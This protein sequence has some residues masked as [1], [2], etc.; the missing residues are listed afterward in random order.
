[1]PKRYIIFAILAT[2]I[3]NMFIVW[4]MS[5]GLGVE[6][7][8]WCWMSNIC[9]CCSFKWGQVLQSVPSKYYKGALTQKRSFLVICTTFS[10]DFHVWWKT[11]NKNSTLNWLRRSVQM[12]WIRHKE[13][14]RLVKWHQVIWKFLLMISRTN[15]IKKN[16]R[17]S[18]NVTNYDFFLNS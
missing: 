9:Y 5:F 15:L 3:C 6:C 10:S 14:L 4:F 17:N 12:T 2:L 1:M 8:N 7:W 13:F 16:W 11:K 18:W